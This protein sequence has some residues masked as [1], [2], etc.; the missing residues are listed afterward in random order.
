[1]SSSNQEPVSPGKASDPTHPFRLTLQR[2]DGVAVG[3][4]VRQLDD[5]LLDSYLPK[6][7]PRWFDPLLLKLSAA[8]TYAPAIA[9]I[10]MQVGA[11]IAA[12][13]LG[14][15]WSS[16]GER[17]HRVGVLASEWP[18]T[19]GFIALVLG[20]ILYVFR[21]RHLFWYGTAEIFFGSLTAFVAITPAQGVSL[22]PFVAGVYV[23]V[24]G[25]DNVHKALETDELRA[26]LPGVLEV[27]NRLFSGKRI[28]RTVKYIG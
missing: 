10:A 15:S 2:A 6:T 8:S 24:R 16:I 21:C 23:I 25:W 18:R 3:A 12:G 14:L 22:V 9:V 27:W 5:V 11:I 28:E 1:M 19:S 17:V 7:K 4:V 13:A 26:L 20:V